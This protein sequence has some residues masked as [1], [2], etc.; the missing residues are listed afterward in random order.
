MVTVLGIFGSSKLSRVLAY[1]SFSV[2]VASNSASSRFTSNYVVREVVKTVVASQKSS[3]WTHYS[4]TRF[5]HCSNACVILTAMD[6]TMVF[7]PE[8]IMVGISFTGSVFRFS[9]WELS[10]YSS[11]H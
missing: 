7:I 2:G 4:R 5:T 11:L 8:N 10:R 3:D 6:W 9:A 1:K